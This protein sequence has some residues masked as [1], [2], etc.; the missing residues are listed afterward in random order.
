MKVMIEHAEV[1]VQRRGTAEFRRQSYADL[2]STHP[3]LADDIE[4]MFPI[5][6]D[7]FATID[8]EWDIG[9]KTWDIQMPWPVADLVLLKDKAVSKPKVHNV[10]GVE[11]EDWIDY[12]YTLKASFAFSLL[13][14]AGKIPP[15]AELQTFG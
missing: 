11:A 7:N 2:R 13:Q 14:G 3:E 1:R 6:A 12:S 10:S 9:P 4:K 8:I 15:D 5:H